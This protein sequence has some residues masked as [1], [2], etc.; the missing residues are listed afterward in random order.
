MKGGNYESNK[1]EN[2]KDNPF[3]WIPSFLDPFSSP[4]PGVPHQTG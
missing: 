2:G 1:M 3:V 4:R